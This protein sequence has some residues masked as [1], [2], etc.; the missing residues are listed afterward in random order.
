MQFF[1]HA[2]VLKGTIENAFRGVNLVPDIT[3][4]ITIVIR[5]PAAKNRIREKKVAAHYVSYK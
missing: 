4:F 1:V 3:T 5:V 2:L